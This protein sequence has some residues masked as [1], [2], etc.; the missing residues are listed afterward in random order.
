MSRGILRGEAV[1]LTVDAIP[2]RARATRAGG[3][4][5][6]CCIVGG[7]PAGLMLAL[8]LARRGVEVTVL[9]AHADFDRD[10][11]GNTINPAAMEVLESLGL[12]DRIREL[13]HAL[14]K[15][16]IVQAGP[17]RETFA[18]FSRLK[19]RY[20]YILMLPQ[21]RFL[22]FVAAEAGRLPNFRILMGARVRE[23]VREGGAVRGVLYDGPDGER[24]KM[25]SDLVVGTDGRFS[26]VR[27]LAGL[28]PVEGDPPMDVVW[29]NVPREEGDPE[30]AGA[31]FRCGRGGL[32]VLMDHFDHWQVGYIIRKGHYSRLKDAGIAAF[33]SAVAELAPELSE[34]VG[35]IEDWRQVS[36]LSVESDRLKRWYAPGLLVIGDAAHVV[37]PVGGIGINLA[38]QDAVE[39]AN[40]LAG[41]LA[42]GRLGTRHLRAVQRRRSPAVRL[43][44]L[45]QE[46]AQRWVVAN[47]LDPEREEPFRLPRSLKLAL[48][49]PILRDL[50]SRLIA[51][52]AWPVRVRGAVRSTEEER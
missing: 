36:L 48:R 6:G 19:T 15:R 24:R 7:G 35:G 28:E 38:I 2:T 46:L 32:L 25:R 17:E 43:V 8:L 45:A 47:A 44:Q 18:D 14:I 31:I 22:E 20:P 23:L 27:K 39:A 3:K 13:R 49:V 21:A 12:A 42:E 1:A 10:F 37:S 26:K 4:Q 30:E 52:G 34:R 33:R 40:V 9:E 5:P 51:F 41:P 29:F 16:F 11:R 50:P